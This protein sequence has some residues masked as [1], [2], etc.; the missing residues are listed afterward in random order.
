MF[1]AGDF[2]LSH[3]EPVIVRLVLYGVLGRCYYIILGS[4]LERCIGLLV[5]RSEWG[6]G[7]FTINI[8]KQRKLLTR[9]H[10]LIECKQGKS[11]TMMLGQWNNIISTY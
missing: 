7:C 5:S 4:D 3:L 9:S 11:H 8:D 2:K 10:I 6:N 1:T